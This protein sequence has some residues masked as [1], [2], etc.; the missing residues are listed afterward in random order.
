MSPELARAIRAWESTYEGLSEETIDARV[1]GFTIL[2]NAIA[3][4]RAVSRDQFAAALGIPAQAAAAA[5]EGLASTGMQFDDKG[6]LVGAALT[7]E[8]TPHRFG[9]RGRELFA[10]CALDTLFLPG[11]LDERATVD[12]SCPASGEA[13]HLDLTPDAILERQP[14]AIGVT[15]ALPGEG[16][17]SARTGPAS[18][19]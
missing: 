9:V 19:T 4:G 10:W 6:D 12:S 11:L 17:A 1:R 2:V 14:E 16:A 3:D 13:I 18:P 7:P 8:P 15:V 5:F